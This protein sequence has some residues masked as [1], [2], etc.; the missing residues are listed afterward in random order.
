MQIPTFFPA[1]GADLNV[2]TLTILHGMLPKVKSNCAGRTFQF[3]IFGP[4]RGMRGRLRVYLRSQK[5]WDI[6]QKAP[7]AR[8]MSAETLALSRLSRR[9]TVPACENRSA[10]QAVPSLLRPHDAL[11]AA[12]SVE[13]N[14]MHRS[15]WGFLVE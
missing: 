5:C 6:R 11:G 10:A 14:R 3:S 1:R 15:R 7:D 2:M 8:R 9:E 4:A 13:S 12:A